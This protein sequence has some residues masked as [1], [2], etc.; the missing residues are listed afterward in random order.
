VHRLGLEGADPCN[1]SIAHEGDIEAP[2]F[3]V[4]LQELLGVRTLA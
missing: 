1:S 4:G 2:G 3:A